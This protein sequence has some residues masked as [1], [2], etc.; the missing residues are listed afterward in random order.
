MVET[1]LGFSSLR[2]AQQPGQQSQPQQPQQ[3]MGQP[4]DYNPMGQHP[5][6]AAGGGH[7]PDYRQPPPMYGGHVPQ[8]DPMSVY[9]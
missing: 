7:E 2:E 1:P 5:M 9:G 3:Q 8:S 4:G 6:V